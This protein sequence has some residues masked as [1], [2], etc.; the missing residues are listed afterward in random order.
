MSDN[1]NK[2]EAITDIS[3]EIRRRWD[4]ASEAYDYGIIEPSE[5][6]GLA[7]RLDA[8]NKRES[9]VIERIVRDAIIS[10]VE[11]FPSAPNDDAEAELKQRAETAN[12]WLV[13]HGFKP[14]AV[15]WSK[16]EVSPF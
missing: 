13:S 16:E 8:A 10:Y 11:W 9:E 3:A 5:I 4:E 1:N 7:E 14:E 2:T 6:I 12:A 15:T